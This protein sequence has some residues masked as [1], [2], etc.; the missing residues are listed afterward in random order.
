MPAIYYSPCNWMRRLLPVILALI[1]Y[2][3]PAMN[4]L[5]ATVWA[6]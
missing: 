2:P 3:L 6:R 1:P 4:S 5:T